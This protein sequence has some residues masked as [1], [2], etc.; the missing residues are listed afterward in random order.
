MPVFSL[1]E[2]DK[3]AAKPDEIIRLGP[4][5]LARY[6]RLTLVRNEATP[7]E[8]QAL[9]QHLPDAYSELETTISTEIKLLRDLLSPLD[10]LPFLQQAFGEFFVAHLGVEDEPSVTF[11]EHGVPARLI[12]YCQSLFAAMP[13][14]LN[15][16][17]HTE[18]DFQNAKDHIRALFQA[19]QNYVS[20]R[21]HSSISGLPNEKLSDLLAKLTYH[22]VGLH[23]VRLTPA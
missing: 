16:R 6:G 3:I 22:W 21:M 9:L 5:V 15:P 2:K 18:A 11:D 14:T 10:P 8:H 1:P 4:L 7:E 13:A 20:L 17:Q 19:T 23:P 12:D